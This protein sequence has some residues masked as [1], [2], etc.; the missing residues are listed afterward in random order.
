MT[1]R[2]TN[3]QKVFFSVADRQL[4]LRLI[5]ENMAEAGVSVL[6]YCLMTNHIHVIAVPRRED[7]LAVLLGRVNGRYAQAVNIHKGRT[8]HL[9][10]ARYYSCALAEERLWIAL[11]YVENNPCRA[12]MVAQPADYR[13][14]SAAAH[15]LGVR[16]R[17]R[18]LDVDFFERAVPRV[19]G[20]AIPSK[21]AP[22]NK[23]AK[24]AFGVK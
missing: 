15:L 23:A 16:G 11:Q 18:A 6:A 13:S 24:G 14:S 3:R 19:N 2:G 21:M 22:G 4:Y 10:Q 7:S 17:S 1:Q 8:G 5:R 20:R 12:G 9:W